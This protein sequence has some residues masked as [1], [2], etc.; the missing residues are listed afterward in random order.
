MSI[1]DFI[2]LGMAPGEYQLTAESVDE[3]DWIRLE[4]QRPRESVTWN[5]QFYPGDFNSDQIVNTVDMDLLSEAILSGQP[6]ISFDMTQ[7]GLVDQAD[8]DL[9]VTANKFFYGDLDLNGAVEFND[10]LTLSGNFGT[11]TNRWADGNIDGEMGVEFGD[12]LLLSANFGNSTIEQAA[13]IPEPTPLA[14]SWLAAIAVLSLRR[15]RSPRVDRHD[16]R[17]R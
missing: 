17:L 5:V 7:D 6:D 3:T 12:F 10:F 1:L 2:G 4:N 9:W 14:A 11:Q 16:L 8:R 15:R 13:I